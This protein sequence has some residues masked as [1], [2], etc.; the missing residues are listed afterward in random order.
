MTEIQN[1][2]NIYFTSNENLLKAGVEKYSKTP[3]LQPDSVELSTKPTE[4]S[5]KN[6]MHC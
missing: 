2:K 3:E 5:K 1:T 6:W 4:K